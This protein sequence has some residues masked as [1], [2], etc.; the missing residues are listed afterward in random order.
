MWYPI[1]IPVYLRHVVSMLRAVINMIKRSALVRLTIMAPRP[2]VDPNVPS[3]QTAPVIWLALVSS[4][5]IHVQ[6]LAAS[7]Q[8]VV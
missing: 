7:T 5:A 4:V 1:A 2:I 3:M 8:N 6:E